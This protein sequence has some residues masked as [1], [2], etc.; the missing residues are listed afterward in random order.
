MLDAVVWTVLLVPASLAGLPLAALAFGSLPSRG[1]FLAKPIG[2]LL[3]AYV[4][5]LL[6]FTGPFTNDRA[7]HLAVLF[8]MAA[9]SIAARYAIPRLRRIKYP[10]WRRI[11]ATELIFAVVFLAYAVYRSRNPEIWGTEK[12]MDFALLNG[13]ILS[14]N[15]PPSDPWFAGHGINYYYFG[16]AV[17]SALTWASG[18]KSAVG[19]NLALGTY[20]ALAFAGV[21]SLGYDLA[22]LIRPLAGRLA[23]YAVGAVTA[24]LVMLGG[25]LY[26]FHIIGDPQ[27]LKFWKGLGWDATRV[28]QSSVDGE[29]VDYT[30]NEFPVFSFIL[31]D[32][33]PHVMALPFTLLA[34]SL[35]VS[36]FVNWSRLSR[37]KPGDLAVAVITGWVLGSLYVINSWDFPSF[38]VLTLIAAAVGLLWFNPHRGLPTIV[39]LIASVAVAAL[40]AVAAFLPFHLQF[41]PFASGIGVVRIRSD[42]TQFLTILGLWVLVAIVYFTYRFRRP[43]QNRHSREGGN[44]HAASYTWTETSSPPQGLPLPPLRK[45]LF[46][47]GPP[48]RLALFACGLLIVGVVWLLSDRMAVFALCS[49]FVIAALATATRSRD[50]LGLGAVSV[51]LFGGFGLAAIPELVFVKDFFGP[52]NTRMNTVFKLYYQVWPIVGVASGAAVYWIATETARLPK[53]R[54]IFLTAGLASIFACLVATSMAYTAIAGKIKTDFFDHVTLDG[55]AF[56]PDVFAS[57][58]DAAE[59]LQENV[60]SHETVL[61][62]SGKPYT[63]YGRISSW[64]GIPTLVGWVQ[65]EQ[66]WRNTDPLVAERVEAIDRIYSSAPIEEAL[67]LL[68]AHRGRLRLRRLARTRQVRLPRRQPVL[69]LA[70]SLPSPRRHHLQSPTT[71]HLNPST[72]RKGACANTH[73]VRCSDAVT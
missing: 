38:F 11:A 52:P 1:A 70:H 17:A 21:W 67:N 28:I 25:N 50:G 36:W 56:A 71:T 72:M 48:V 19:F 58:V 37:F 5:W 34:T 66:L 22:G 16:Y 27:A 33:H 62:A 13:I 54:R 73:Q 51:L 41:E 60:A 23:N 69:L 49:V 53:V 29:L 42:I 47:A 20:L 64:T 59:W 68:H 35:A 65:H 40:V 2:V 24:A 32:L 8:G 43:L 3:V 63:T 26:V 46:R 12:P 39:S 10:T 44:P 61:E 7:F 31:G 4:G 9:I 57:D 45:G 18:V 30:I 55:L 6:L 15:F 14:P